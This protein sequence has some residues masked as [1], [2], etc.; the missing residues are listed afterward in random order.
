MFGSHQCLIKWKLFNNIEY[1]ITNVPG[2]FFFDE[3]TWQII[4][5]NFYVPKAATLQIKCMWLCKKSP[6]L[7][8]YQLL[9]IN[10]NRTSI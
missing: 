9:K 5:Q 7:Y 10:L 6:N 2:F 1:T 8:N 4:H 3:N